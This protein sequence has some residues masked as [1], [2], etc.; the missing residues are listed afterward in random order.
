MKQNSTPLIGNAGRSRTLQA[1]WLALANLLSLSVTLVMQAV[2]CRYMTTSEYG[3]YSQ[4]L[5][6][7]NTLLVVFSLGLPKAY[8]YYLA[9]VS[10]EEGRDIVRKLNGLFLLLASVFSCILLWQAAAIA[11]VLGNPLLAEPLRLFAAAPMLLMPVLGGGE[12]ILVV[13]GKAHLVAGYV[14]ISRAFM[15][16]CVVLPVVVFDAGVSG[17]IAGFVLASLVTCVAGQKLSSVP[18]RNVSPVKSRLTVRELLRFSMP[19]FASSMYGFV[20]GS[21]S[22]FLVSRYLGVEDFALF[23][24]GYRELPLAGM[25]IGAAAGVLLPEFS[26]MSVEG[27]DGGQFV[28]L[29]QAAVLKSSAIIY[30]LSV[31]CC[32]FAPEIICLLYGEGYR[33]AAGLFRI[34][35]LVNLARIMPYAPVLFALGRGKAFARAHLVTALLIVGLELWCVMVFPSL[36]AIAAIATGCTFFCLFLLMTTTARV[37]GT[38]LAGLMPWRMLTIVLLVS[39]AACTAAR[40]AVLLT[41]M[42]HHLVVV[43]V[44]FAVYLSLYLPFAQRAGI[45]YM[46]LFGPVLAKLRPNRT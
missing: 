4:V 28:R 26:R 3:T 10:P 43:S 33:E 35:T 22:Q 39:A 27:A 20:I 44:G 25:I 7:Y 11:G 38:S 9:R 46:E 19:V 12:N 29:W 42:T 5:Y 24:N 21:A 14:L 45:C 13:Y 30:P 2:L 18:F 6:V 32:V 31:F 23:A 1:L 37:L 40:L 16:A 41:G 17:A 8:S 36:W 34:V 15:I